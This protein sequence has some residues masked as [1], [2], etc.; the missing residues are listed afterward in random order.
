MLQ[1]E[2][3]PHSGEATPT[4]RFD[5][6]A[7]EAAIWD[8]LV[9]V[10]EDPHREGL[11]DTPARIARACQKH[12]SGLHA[13]PHDILTTSSAEQHDELVLF[14][15]I[16]VQS[17]C[18]HHLALIH[19]DAHIGYLPGHDGRL[20]TPSSIARLVD[21]LASRPQT[22]DRLT[23]HIADTLMRKMNPRG[24]VVLV[25]AEHLCT[26]RRGVRRPTAVSTSAVRGHF[27]TDA[28]SR[29]EA[30]RLLLRA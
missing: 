29:A 11:R 8:L 26:V 16:P 1:S 27:S 7:V 4:R 17:L 12:F 20:P 10:G 2:E 6:A 9:A 28:A 25:E 18:D 22:Q 5:R 3:V 19:G 13:D 30:R 14:K 15:Q 24:V 23:R 21:L